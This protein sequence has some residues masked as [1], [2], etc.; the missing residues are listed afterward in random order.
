MQMMHMPT[1]LKPIYRK[2]F[3]LMNHFRTFDEIESRVLER[4][5]LLQSCISKLQVA[6]VSSY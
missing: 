4:S 1:W 2:W 5:P 3:M 6:V